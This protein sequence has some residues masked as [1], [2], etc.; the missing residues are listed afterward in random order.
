M[1]SPDLLRLLG[2]QGR[3]SSP[4]YGPAEG[5]VKGPGGRPQG[6]LDAGSRLPRAP[7]PGAVLP[8]ENGRTPLDLRAQRQGRRPTR[9]ICRPTG[10]RTPLERRQGVCGAPMEQDAGRRRP[11]PAEDHGF[12]SR[13][14]PRRH[15]PH[16]RPGFPTHGPRQEWLYRLVC[17]PRSGVCLRRRAG[18]RAPAGV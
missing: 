6:A 11:G 4:G 17:R 16:Q 13:Q 10:P 12:L 15:S 7:D 18:A 14:C 2:G 1:A 8:A 3:P 5:I 9:S